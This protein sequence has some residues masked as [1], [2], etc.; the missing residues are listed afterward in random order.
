MKWIENNITYDNVDSYVLEN[1]PWFKEF[2]YIIY[3]DSDRELKYEVFWSLTYFFRDNYNNID[4]T[5][6]IIDAIHTIYQT[7]DKKLQDLILS[8]FIENLVENDKEK[9][10]NLK[11]IF[12]YPELQDILSKFY[13]LDTL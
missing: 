7:Q 6:N 3:D 10:N 9:M 2:F 13:Y 12:R 1:I 8:G 11:E 5:R 4:V